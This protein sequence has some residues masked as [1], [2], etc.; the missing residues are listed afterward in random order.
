MFHRILSFLDLLEIGLPRSL[1]SRAHRIASA[2]DVADVQRIARR[3]LPR[4]AYDYVEGGA[5][6]EQAVHRNRAA[7]QRIA[8]SPR[9][10]SGVAE[11]AT[12]QSL[13]GQT[14][15]LPVGIA[16]TGLTSLMHPEGELGGVRA[17]ERANVPFVL[18]TMSTRSIEEVAAAAPNAARWFQLYLRRDRQESLDLLD[19]AARAGYDKLVLTVDTAVPGRRLRDTRNGLSLP[20]RLTARTFISALQH[21]AWTLGLLREEAPGLAN[22]SDS[23]GPMSEIVSRMFDPTQSWDDF[24]TIR[25]H[26]SGDLIVKGVLDPSDAQECV[27]RGADA[28]WVSNHGGRQLDRAV[29]PADAVGRIR[30]ALGPEVPVI[31]DS[32]I[33]S[34][35][36]VIA[37]IAAGADF[38]FVG[39]AYIYGL[40]AGGRKGVD[41][42]LDI[43]HEEMLNS[44]QLL[45]IRT[46]DELSTAHAWDQQTGKRTSM[47]GEQLQ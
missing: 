37:A 16:P 22:F 27:R 18:S 46:W 3:R 1:F 4:F 19:R 2:V 47:K 33:M 23:N 44:M 28:I 21:P 30:A 29:S 17:A 39:R 24:D 10:L 41:R 31:L 6:Q 14:Y 42:V 40:A 20:P 9:V 25:S 43:L 12:R 11:S 13:L 7:L 38:T 15:D 36:D 34:G 32:G 5:F 26:W 35:S 45:G 8:F